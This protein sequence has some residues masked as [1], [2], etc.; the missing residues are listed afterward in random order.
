MGSCTG[1][2]NVG[3]VYG[4]AAVI[5]YVII[6]KFI[7][8]MILKQGSFHREFWDVHG[9]KSGFFFSIVVLLMLLVYFLGKING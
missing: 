5:I 7:K 6:L 2:N 1:N 3:T 4:L 9:I 8:V